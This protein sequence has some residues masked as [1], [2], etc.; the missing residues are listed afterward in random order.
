MGILNKNIEIPIPNNNI[1]YQL[2]CLGFKYKP[3][4]SN[5]GFWALKINTIVNRHIVVTPDSKHPD[6]W[7]FQ[8]YFMDRTPIMYFWRT[9]NDVYHL[10]QMVYNDY[11]IS[12]LDNYESVK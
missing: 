2:E 10:A 1:D 7:V 11:H 8:Y 12:I 4:I 5:K 9:F 6:R 3:G